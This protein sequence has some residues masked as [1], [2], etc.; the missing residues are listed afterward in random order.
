M[1][2]KLS[3]LLL[4]LIFTMAMVAADDKAVS[5]NVLYDQVRMKLVSDLTVKGGSLGVVVEQGVVTMTGKVKT[6]K[7]KEKATKLAKGV[8]GVKSVVNKLV[9]DPTTP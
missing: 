3:A 8:K 5:D 1:I 6:E 4:S 9:V 2:L 7:A